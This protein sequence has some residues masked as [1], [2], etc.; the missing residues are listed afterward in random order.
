MPEPVY[1]LS[2]QDI[3]RLRTVVK[4]MEGAAASPPGATIG[5]RG[6]GQG[7]GQNR[8]SVLIGDGDLD[9]RRYPAQV[10]LRNSG[11]D[12]VWEPLGE[13]EDVWA[14]ERN[15]LTLEADSYYGGDMIGEADDG[16]P[17]FLVDNC[18]GEI[19]QCLALDSA[20]YEID[21]ITG[22]DITV[23]VNRYGSTAGTVGCSYHTVDGTA[24]APTDYENTSGT[25]SFADGIGSATFTITVEP[26]VSMSENLNFSV[27]IDTPTGAA[28]I[29][30]GPAEAIITAS[31]TAEGTVAVACCPGVLLGPTLYVELENLSGCDC[32]DGVTFAIVLGGHSG[33]SFGWAGCSGELA[34]GEVFSLDVLC[35]YFMTDFVVGGE[36]SYPGFACTGVYNPH[37]PMFATT[38]LMT[39]ATLVSLDCGPGV[40]ELVIDAT[41]TERD[42]GIPSAACGVSGTVRI[43]IT[44]VS[45]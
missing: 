45:T 39:D 12:G 24:E 11:G 9:G 33:S 23:T 30:E 20:T 29:C 2:E 16:K 3:P 37:P 41:I 42:V 27:V 40:F 13:M 7:G 1:G 38:G 5:P 21:G 17:V 4:R 10:F 44:G 43:T 18:C 6:G 28:S 19:I 22:G 15:G 26:H 31:A 35:L 32:L 36:L 8:Q 34:C 14:E 25:L